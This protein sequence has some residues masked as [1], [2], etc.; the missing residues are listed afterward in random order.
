MTTPQL[1]FILHVDDDP[2]DLTTWLGAVRESGRVDIEVVP[3][4]DVTAEHLRRASLVL[5][6]FRIEHWPS[7]TKAAALALKPV[8]GLALLSVLQEAAYELDKD[9]PRA[10]ALFTAVV[11]D[12][13]RG[14]IPRPYIVARAHNLEWVFDK[15]DGDLPARVSRVAELSEAIQGLPS[16][17]P[18]D[19]AEHA[20][21]AL[22]RW[23]GIPSE[24]VWAEG[25]WDGVMRCRPPMHEF[26][27]HTHGIGVLRW[28]LHRIWPY[29]T[30]LIDDAHLAARLRV[31]ARSLSSELA[32]N[33]DLQ[34]LLMPAQYDGPLAGFL[35][36]RWWRAAV[37]SIIFN[38]TP[39]DPANIAALHERLKAAAPKLALL[40]GTHFPVLD[41]RFCTQE[42]LASATEV[43]EVVPDDWP[44]FADSAWALR[45][46]LPDNPSLAAVATGEEET[47]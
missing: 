37:E 2:D 22:R 5:V 25:A 7:R 13:A 29:P 43:V 32:A 19:S 4:D 15:A 23:L 12:V 47:G 34:K 17:W 14:L 42:V 1:P 8:N 33:T 16:P 46:D 3:P 35:G 21:Q 11:S 28:A 41:G 6:D 24:A 27:E 30:F 26:A 9:R 18:G 31:E 40:D 36:R 39:D 44:P 38:T 20:G 10:F 45:S